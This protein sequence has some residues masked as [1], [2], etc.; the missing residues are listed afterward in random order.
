[1]FEFYYKNMTFEFLFT[2]EII[3]DGAEHNPSV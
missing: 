3:Q 2:F 1:M